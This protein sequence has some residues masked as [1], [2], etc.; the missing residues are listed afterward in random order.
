VGYH[1]CISL[2]HKAICAVCCLATW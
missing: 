2:V 1:N